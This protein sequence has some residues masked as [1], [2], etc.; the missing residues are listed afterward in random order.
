ML[1]K[2]QKLS[3]VLH[4]CFINGSVVMSKTQVPTDIMSSICTS[5]CHDKRCIKFSWLSPPCLSEKNRKMLQHPDQVT[6]LGVRNTLPS[7]NFIRIIG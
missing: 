7:K 6:L 2:E 1:K 3:L 4:D 5:D